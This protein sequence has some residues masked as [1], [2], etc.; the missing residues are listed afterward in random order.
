ML[1]RIFA[2]IILIVSFVLTITSFGYEM[3]QKY[4]SDSYTDPIPEIQLPEI[5]EQRSIY[6]YFNAEK[7]PLEKD[8]VVKGG[9]LYVP[10][11]DLFP[12]LGFTVTIDKNITLNAE[13]VTAV[14]KKNSNKGTVNGKEIQLCAKVKKINGVLMAP[15]DLVSEVLN[16]KIWFDAFSNTFAI[17]TGSYKSDDIL[18]IIN[19]KFWMNGQPFYEISFNKWD[20]FLQISSSRSRESG[21]SSEEYETKAAEDALRSLHEMGFRTIRVFASSTLRNAYFRSEKKKKAFY[22]VCDE[23]FDLCDKYDIQVVVCMSLPYKDFVAKGEDLFDL[24]CD[25]ESDSRQLCYDFLA[26]YISKYKDRRSVLMWEITNEGNLE[27][28]I[29]WT[30][31]KD[32]YSIYQLGRF[33]EDCANKIKEYDPVKPVTGGDSLLSKAQWHQYQ[34]V[35]EG[36]IGT[37]W[38][39]D[40]LEQRLKA[41]WL[42]H[43]GL[44]VV[45]CHY[46]GSNFVSY[47]KSETDPTQVTESYYLVMDEVR[48]IGKVLYNGEMWGYFYDE[49][50]GLSEEYMKRTS[51]QV[52][53]LIDAGVQLSHWW[54]YHT[55]ISNATSQYNW[56]IRDGALLDLIIAKNKELQQRWIVNSIAGAD[57]TK[58][59]KDMDDV[60]LDIGITVPSDDSVIIT[61]N[62]CSGSIISYGPLSSAV[63]LL[64]LLCKKKSA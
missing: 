45:S 25:P 19:Y 42:I 31:K 38:T 55:D 23:F 51:D 13:G 53:E 37:D 20:L 5:P 52:D 6:V 29:G 32:S 43:H 12:K 10:L 8:P 46:I 47:A 9:I 2:A 50:E 41:Y 39:T 33:Y 57:T 7:V 54:T 11:L 26:E 17:S 1:K 34:G 28:D 36:R 18:R 21:W 22:E 48:S 60:C 30:T 24:I 4:S 59:W 44:D 63:I 61:G 27:A 62:G 15:S 56:Q 64:G 40:T 14:F 49:E 16:A 58:A 35:K 3:P